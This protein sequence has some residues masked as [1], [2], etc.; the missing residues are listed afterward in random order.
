[1]SP[2]EPR[3]TFKSIFPAKTL[4]YH[5]SANPLRTIQVFEVEGSAWEVKFDTKRIPD[6]KN[7]HFEE[8]IERRNEQST[9]IWQYEV[10]KYGYRR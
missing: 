7:K 6:K 3:N 1:M 9:H 8:N 5:K 10:F 2:R 4:I